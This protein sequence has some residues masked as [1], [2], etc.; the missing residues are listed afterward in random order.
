[1]A[2]VF[3]RT[4]LVTDPKTGKQ[5]RRKTKKWYGKYEDSDGIIQRV[6]LS[7]NK[8]VAEQMLAELVKQS[9]LGKV[10]LVDPFEASRKMPLKTHV[11]DFRQ[12]LESKGN[13]PR[14]V[15]MTKARVEAVFDGCGFK[16]LNDLNS[17]K[18]SNWLK[19]QRDEI[20]TG[21]KFGYATSNH[22]LIAVKSFG[23][24]L[25]RSRRSER[26]PFAHLSRLN[27]KVDV[28]VER[29]AMEADEL[30]RLIEAAKNSPAIYRGLTG[31]DRSTLYLVATMTGLRANELATLRVSAFNFK[32]DPPTVTVEAENEKSGR[33]AELPLHPG[34]VSRLATWLRTRPVRATSSTKKIANEVLWPGTWVERAAEMLRSD[35]AEAR[36]AW[37][38][39]VESNPGELERRTESDFLKP[40]NENGEKADFHALRHSFITLLASSGVHPKVAQQLARHST[41]TL[42]MDR[43]SHARLVDLNAAVKNLPSLALENPLLS[44]LAS[45]NQVTADD[46]TGPTTGPKLGPISD[47]RCVS[48]TTVDE[49]EGE[50]RPASTMQKPIKN[51]GIAND[52]AAVT[53]GDENGAAGIRTQNQ[54][55]MSPLL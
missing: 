30:S 11:E 24:W 13:S 28:R 26:N 15:S 21:Q 43:Y 6:P 38:K 23:N 17:D 53:T 37:L 44:K 7:S 5:T 18:V 8:T 4:Y 31:D 49:T 9:E 50:I 22:H 16:R 51:R 27:T 19:V 40:V 33:G 3:K 1:M 47:C 35:L 2:S 39:E 14:H 32:V 29:R 48:V 41:I 55:I 45:V 25:L 20:K 34:V 42:T 10:G 52:G 12:H 46:S 54:R 36:E